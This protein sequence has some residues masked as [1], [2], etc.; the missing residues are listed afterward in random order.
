MDGEDRKDIDRYDNKNRGR[1]SRGERES[2]TAAD[3][4]FRSRGWEREGRNEEL[5][6][7]AQGASVEYKWKILGQSLGGRRSCQQQPST[8]AGDL[9]YSG[10]RWAAWARYRCPPLQKSGDA[11]V[12]S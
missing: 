5:G 9:Q 1:G 3:F 2:G 4:S 6:G 10:L 12:S 11:G 8:G 7:E